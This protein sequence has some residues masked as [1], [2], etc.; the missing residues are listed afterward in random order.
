[1]VRKGFRFCLFTELQFTLAER[2]GLWI[3]A[4][5]SSRKENHTHRNR[6]KRQTPKQIHHVGESESHG[7][8]ID[9]KRKQEHAKGWRALLQNYIAQ[10]HNAT[11]TCP[12]AK[13]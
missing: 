10:E 1:M 12:Q 5:V 13:V 4:V 2:Q 11:R 8:P 9:A 6:S 3:P 7:S